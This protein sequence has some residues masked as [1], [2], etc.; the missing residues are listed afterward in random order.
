M[1]VFTVFVFV[2]IGCGPARPKSASLS[3]GMPESFFLEAKIDIDDS[4]KVSYA[5]ESKLD[6]QFLYR[7]ANDPFDGMG[8][9]GFIDL[10][11]SYKS[12]L[13]NYIGYKYASADSGNGDYHIDVALEECTYE[14][15]DAGYFVKVT[16]NLVVK[17]RINVNGNVSEKKITGIGESTGYW[18]NIN[19][20]TNSFDLA[21]RATISR[22][23]RFLNSAINATTPDT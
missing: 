13:E 23:D 6:D 9:G 22:M 4:K 11:K 12:I 5:F 7:A 21:I 17:V 15:A 16:T 1:A 14:E 19:T 2:F 8:K 18:S 10:N 3:K 20:V